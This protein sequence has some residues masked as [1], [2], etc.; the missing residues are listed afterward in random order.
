MIPVFMTLR[1]ERWKISG[2]WH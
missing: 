1:V 2:Q